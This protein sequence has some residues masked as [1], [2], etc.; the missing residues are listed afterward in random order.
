MAIA[1]RRLLTLPALPLR[2]LFDSPCLNS[3]ITLPAI[4]FWRDDVFAMLALLRRFAANPRMSAM[5][6]ALARASKRIPLDC[7]LF[8]KNASILFFVPNLS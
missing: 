5:F 3:C 7:N 8:Q 6:H 1:R 2:P 4:L